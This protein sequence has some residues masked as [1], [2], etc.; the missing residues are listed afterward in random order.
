MMTKEQ[1]INYW[2]EIAADDWT[3]KEILF[4]A[5]D[6]VFCLYLAHQALEKLAKANWVRT[7]QENYP[8]RVHN[9]VYLLEQS[10]VDLGNDLMEFLGLFNDFQLSGRYPDYE[11]KINKLCTREFTV[12][13]LETVNEIRSCLLEMLQLT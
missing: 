3:R 5:N 9:I 7:H 2:V 4:N 12:G 1:H 8:P 10:D 6:Y 11:R 13:K